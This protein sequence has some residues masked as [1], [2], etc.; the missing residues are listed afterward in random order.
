M[1]NNYCR[2]SMFKVAALAVCLETF[3]SS[4]K[5]QDKLKKRFLL[6]SLEK[7]F[8]IIVRSERG[9]NL[10]RKEERF[11]LSVSLASFWQTKPQ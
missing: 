1:D 8:I 10:R 5:A 6:L 2:L 11:S 4:F 3:S 9:K 7:L